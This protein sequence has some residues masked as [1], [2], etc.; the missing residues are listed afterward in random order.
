MKFNIC[1]HDLWPVLVDVG[2]IILRFK[3]MYTFISFIFNLFSKWFVYINARTCYDELTRRRSRSNWQKRQK[4]HFCRICRICLNY[5]VSSF[6]TISDFLTRRSKIRQ[7][8]LFEF[9]FSESRI[10]KI[11]LL[12]SFKFDILSCSFCWLKLYSNILGRNVHVYFIY[13]QFIFSRPD[14]SDQSQTTCW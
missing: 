14:A 1:K 9:G 10:S 6:S 7:Q 4:R 13:F 8:F 12:I 3:H 2:T 5:S 11:S